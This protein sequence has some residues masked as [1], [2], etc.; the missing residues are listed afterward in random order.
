[1]FSFRPPWQRDGSVDGSCS[2][3]RAFSI[4]RGIAT[5]T[6]I[7]FSEH[8]QCARRMRKASV[9]GMTCAIVTNDIIHTRIHV[10]DPLDVSENISVVQIFWKSKGH[11]FLPPSKKDDDSRRRL[12]IIIHH[13]HHLTLRE[14][15]WMR[16]VQ[17]SPDNDDTSNT[18]GSL[19]YASSRVVSL[20]R[21]TVRVQSHGRTR[22]RRTQ[23][24]SQHTPKRFLRRC[25][26]TIARSNN[27]NHDEQ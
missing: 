23:N 16:C 1:M 18:R 12:I 8:R 7:S 11:R 26:K 24:H 22:P 19:Q 2:S 10:N 9:S 4:S 27:H 13:H 14:D 17:P 5:T 25:S 20:L 21:S 15:R 3:L 6:A